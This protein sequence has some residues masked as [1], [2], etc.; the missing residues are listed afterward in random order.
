MVP[1][2]KMSVAWGDTWG[3][4]ACTRDSGLV[5]MLKLSVALRLMEKVVVLGELEMED[6]V[7]LRC[8]LLVAMEFDRSHCSGAA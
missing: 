8:M 1:R 4:G 3:L 7:D 6:M 5:L 2:E